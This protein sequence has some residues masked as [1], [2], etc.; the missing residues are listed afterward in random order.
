MRVQLHQH[1]WFLRMVRIESWASGLTDGQFIIPL[2][3]SA[4]PTDFSTEK[5]VS[6]Q[7]LQ[8]SREKVLMFFCLRR[9]FPAD[10]NVDP[11]IV[12]ISAIF[13]VVK[14]ILDSFHLKNQDRDLLPF[15]S[16]VPPT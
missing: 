13:I 5:H 12:E 15:I 11:K 6:A 3:V 7:S 10:N 2:G 4:L 1:C 8:S 9:S 16:K 14:A